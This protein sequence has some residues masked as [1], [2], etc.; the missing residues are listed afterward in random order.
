M[1]S[2]VDVHLS[3]F[4]ADLVLRQDAPQR[5]SLTQTLPQGSAPP[6]TTALTMPLVLPEALSHHDSS[7]STSL[8]IQEGEEVSTVST[9]EGLSQD[10]HKQSAA[11]GYRGTVVRFNN[12]RP[13]YVW[14]DSPD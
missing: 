12:S 3:K 13:G 8:Q 10:S 6:H 7:P 14:Q 9:G 1:T 11:A 2:Q 4:I 5:P